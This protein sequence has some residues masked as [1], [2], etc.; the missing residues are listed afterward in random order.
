MLLLLNFLSYLIEWEW[1]SLR[2]TKGS[3]DLG[4]R[5]AYRLPSSY[6]L[7]LFTSSSV[8]RSWGRVFSMMIH[9]A[10]VDFHES[11]AHLT[12]QLLA[13]TVPEFSHLAPDPSGAFLTSTSPSFSF[14]QL[15]L[16]TSRLEKQPSLRVYMPMAFLRVDSPTLHCTNLPRG[17][18]G[19]CLLSH[20]EASI[21]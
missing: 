18:W 5:Y 11:S 12:S 16:Q 10:H 19:G 8:K 15:R 1:K 14:L 20:H 6:F 21:L 4:W 3:R 17:P 7:S 13:K 9:G 2:F